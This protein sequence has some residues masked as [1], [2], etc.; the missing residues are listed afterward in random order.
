MLPRSILQCFRPALSDYQSW[1]SLLLSSFEWPL[2]RGLTVLWTDQNRWVC[3]HQHQAVLFHSLLK[4]SKYMIWSL[5]WENPSMVFL[6]RLVSS[7]PGGKP[8]R[9]RNY[10]HW[11]KEA[12][13][14]KEADQSVQMYIG[15]GL[16]CICIKLVFS[17]HGSYSGRFLICLHLHVSRVMR[18][19]T[20]WILTRS[21][22]NQAVQL[23]ETIRG[24][25]FCI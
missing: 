5:L 13:N 15:F 12:V 23:L 21:D 18:K 20:I 17:W 7:W 6:T 1:K 9:Y 10:S 4:G 3:H 2:K 16:F 19:Q 14:S 8:F 22:T 11:T 25:K 24:L